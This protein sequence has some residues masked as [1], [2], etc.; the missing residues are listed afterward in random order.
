MDLAGILAGI[1]QGDTLAAYFCDRLPWLPQDPL[2]HAHHAP[3]EVTTQVHTQY[4]ICFLCLSQ[5]C[6]FQFAFH[7]LV[8]R[9]NVLCDPLDLNLNKYHL[10]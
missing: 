7:V 2:H 1:E 10:Q 5:V 4:L 6:I 3:H 8:P 9:I